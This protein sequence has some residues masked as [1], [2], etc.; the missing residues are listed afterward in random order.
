VTENLKIAKQTLISNNYTCVIVKDKK[1]V[2]TSVERGVKP[3]YQALEKYSNE[4]KG[5]SLADKVIGKGAALLVVQA[6]I[7]ELF[8]D[9]LSENA[10]TVLE[11]NNIIFYCNKL[12]P[13]ILNRT[14]NDFCPVEKLT[15][16]INEP[17]QALSVIKEF[18]ENL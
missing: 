15:K 17:Q 13:N 14:G 6:G 16:D 9:I 2:F 18:L 5:S 10:K 3:I 8:T 1:V 12:V 7:R 11:N 4:L